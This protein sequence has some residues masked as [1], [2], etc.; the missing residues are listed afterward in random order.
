MLFTAVR[1]KPSHFTASS[2]LRENAKASMA[3]A[4]SG[5]CSDTRTHC[6]HGAAPS[7][8]ASHPHLGAKDKRVHNHEHPYSRRYQ[9]HALLHTSPAT[10]CINT[11]QASMEA[12]TST[13][14]LVPL[15][16]ARYHW[17]RYR[18]NTA[19]SGTHN[20]ESIR[21]VYT[22]TPTHLKDHPPAAST[23]GSP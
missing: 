16:V 15:L 5:I 13:A 3:A 22:I 4:G 2:T 10:H 21:A 1:S 7:G 17:Q 23:A 12:A 6:A 20:R 11:L 14:G 8:D 9:P 18:A 19:A